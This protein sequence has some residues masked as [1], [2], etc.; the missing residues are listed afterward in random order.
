[1]IK[2]RPSIC[3]SASGRHRDEALAGP[4]ERRPQK[5]Q[6]LDSSWGRRHDSFRWDGVPVYF[7]MPCNW[8]S[9]LL[10]LDSRDL[11]KHFVRARCCRQTHS[12]VSL[13][14]SV[15]MLSSIGAAVGLAAGRRKAFLL[16]LEAQ[17]LLCQRQVE[18]NTRTA[19]KPRFPTGR[20]ARYIHT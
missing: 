10:D 20:L 7:P 1:M 6:A 18:L 16:K 9:D 2:S 19:S 15:L 3:V 14:P 12:G 8:C 17:K 4:S 11:T 13:P 5:L